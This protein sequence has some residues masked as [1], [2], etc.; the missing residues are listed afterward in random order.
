[1]EGSVGDGIRYSRPGVIARAIECE[2]AIWIEVHKN[3]NGSGPEAFGGAEEWPV[4]TLRW[5][6]DESA[7]SQVDELRKQLQAFVDSHMPQLKA[8]NEPRAS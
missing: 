7:S 6:F 3:Y 2:D 4:I 5:S 8:R 1:V